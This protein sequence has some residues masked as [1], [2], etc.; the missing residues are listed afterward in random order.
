MVSPDSQAT[1]CPP[2]GRN[3]TY[4]PVQISGTGSNSEYEF[5]SQFATRHS[6]R[7]KNRRWFPSGGFLQSIIVMRR[8]SSLAGLA[9]TYSS[10]S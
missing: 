9:A 8:T 10:K 5:Y 3:S 4:H 6:L 2:S 7:K 1:A